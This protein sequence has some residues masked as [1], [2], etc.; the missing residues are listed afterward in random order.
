M[1]C[2]SSINYIILTVEIASRQ[3]ISYFKS[4]GFR[5]DPLKRNWRVI[6]FYVACVPG[7]FGVATAMFHHREDCSAISGDNYVAIHY[8]V[9]QTFK[10]DGYTEKFPFTW[11]ISL[12]TSA[13]YFRIVTA[14]NS[15]FCF[16]DM[17]ENTKSDRFCRAVNFDLY[18]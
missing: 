11:C 1:W 12:L 16:R 5:R 8:D 18:W 3:Q 9:F 10:C 13:E 7:E 6:T 17:L 4:R 15:S 2:E 14:R